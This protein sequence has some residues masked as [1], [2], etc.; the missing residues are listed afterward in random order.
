MQRVGVLRLAAQYVAIAAFRLGEA[1]GSMVLQREREGLICAEL[2]H[3]SYRVSPIAIANVK[4]DA[5]IVRSS[6]FAN[7]QMRPPSVPE[8]DSSQERRVRAS[9]DR[10]ASRRFVPGDRSRNP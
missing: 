1:A 10:G 4:Y 7:A 3:G 2:R 8:T 5:R 6:G 9:G